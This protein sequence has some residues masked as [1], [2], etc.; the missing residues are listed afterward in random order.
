MAEYNPAQLE[1]P[2][3]DSLKSWRTIDPEFKDAVPVKLVP[4][5]KVPPLS[6]PKVNN[7]N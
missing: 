3:A 4:S 5:L 1:I 6:S 2:G 7:V